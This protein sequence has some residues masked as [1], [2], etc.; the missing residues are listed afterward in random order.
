MIVLSQ[1]CNHFEIM[2]SESLGLCA[3][4]IHPPEDIYTSCANQE[5]IAKIRCCDT[6]P[7]TVESLYITSTDSTVEYYDSS[8]S[9]WE[10]V[11][12]M[13]D[14]R[15]GTYW[16]DLD[17]NLCDWV[18]SEERATGS[19]GDWFRVLV[20]TECSAVDT[21][22]IRIQ[23][24][25][26]A[27]IYANDTYIDTTHG[28]PGSGSTGWRMLHE[29]DLTP[30]FNGGVDTVDI[31]GYNSGGI[32]GLIFEIVV[33]CRR[34]CCGNIDPNTISL[35][36]DGWAYSIFDDYLEWDNDSLLTFTPAPPILYENGQYV[37]AEV[38][39]AEDSCG[40]DLDTSFFDVRTGFYVDLSPPLFELVY[41]TDIIHDEMPDSITIFIDDSL[42][43]LDSSS[44]I[45]DAGSGW[46]DLG[47]NGSYFSD[48]R[49]FIDPVAAGIAWS[50]GDSI[51]I[52]VSAH[53]SPDLCDPNADTVYYSWFMRDPDAPIAEFIEPEPEIYTSCMPESIVVT[54]EDFYGIDESTI[55]FWVN[56]IEY[57][58]SSPE[59][60]WNEPVLVFHADSG[61]PSVDTVIAELRHAQ[62]HFGNDITSPIQLI[63]MTDYYPPTAEFLLPTQ[64][65]VRDIYQDI[66]ISFDDHGSGVDE[67]SIELLVD[68]V[69]YSSTELDI[70]MDGNGGEVYFDPEDFGQRFLNGDTI[71][72]CIDMEDSPDRCSPNFFSDCWSFIIEPSMT[73]GIAPNPFTPNDDG[74]N[75]RLLFYYP[76]LFSE[77]VEIA[78]F[79]R[80][81][82]EVWRSKAPRQ[83]IIGDVEGRI[84]DG[85]DTNN[86]KCRPGL[87]FYTI[88]QDGE[89]ICNGTITLIR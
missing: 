69:H 47:E 39:Y 12:N 52:W 85:N 15:W 17:T 22:F 51:R 16:V 48:G 7:S 36:V 72:V 46:F 13:E 24:D 8:T 20:E 87:Y 41:P 43:G 54:I 10:P 21:A 58:I 59:I 82:A 38:L 44:T 64:A 26:Q 37:E 66:R 57:D 35:M 71:V 29:F 78:I 60:S 89:I 40:W 61:W 63:F 25:N 79:D 49:L 19:H 23:A 5:I 6:M 56:G 75:D 65:M 30:Y 9:S 28:N 76:R 73:C 42:S 14:D 27:T 1:P 55:E 67:T 68:S 84:W 18:W 34:G 45:I 11:Y 4:F 81:K 77:E 62:D 3:D 53:D 80:Y 33:V 88:E 86:V 70:R 74:I 31:M 83:L 50:P 32:A 2:L